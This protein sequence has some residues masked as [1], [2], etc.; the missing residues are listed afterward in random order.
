MRQIKALAGLLG[1]NGGMP[2]VAPA[3]PPTTPSPSARG[4]VARWREV[5]WPRE[6]GS[7]SFALEPLALGLIAA[8]S[9][10][11]ACLA[12]AVFA[13][14]LARRPLRQALSD[15]QPARR[16]EARGP[17][18]L[19]SLV[20]LVGL[21]GAVGWGGVAWLQWLVPAAAAGALFLRFDLRAAGREEI[22]E[23]AGTSAFALV[24]AALAAL[25]GWSPESG[26][27]LALLMVGRAAPSVLTVRACVRAAKTGERRVAPALIST[28]LALVVAV[29]FVR[30][31]IAPAAAAWLLALFAARSLALLVWPRP[32]LR[33]RTLGMIET[34]LGAFFVLQVASR[35]LSE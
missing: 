27:A 16:A 20:A 34:V 13:G 32:A 24:P 31:G 23:V 17:L 12:L 33:A 3:G 22:A 25:A 4:A 8:P 19:I 29:G 7:W 26:A 5:V 14:F 9:L 21:A 28:G 30:G 6:H 11:G 1:Q 18:A 2:S 15:P 10:A 35:W